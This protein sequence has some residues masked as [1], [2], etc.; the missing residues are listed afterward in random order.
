MNTRS[1]AN[2]FCSISPKCKLRLQTG[3]SC[4]T[5]IC[6]S[7]DVLRLMLYVIRTLSHIRVQSAHLYSTFM[8]IMKRMHEEAD[9][10]QCNSGRDIHQRSWCDV[11]MNSALQHQRTNFKLNLSSEIMESSGCLSR[12]FHYFCSERIIWMLQHVFNV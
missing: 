1:N 6:R 12:S 9:P 8:D 5:K 10:Y 2:A 3:N 11:D 4:D 7:M